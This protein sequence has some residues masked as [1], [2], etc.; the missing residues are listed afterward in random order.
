MCEKAVY[1][2]RHGDKQ[3]LLDTHNSENWG[4][5]IGFEPKFSR[6][7]FYFK[8]AEQG[9]TN[10]ETSESVPMYAFY[11]SFLGKFQKLSI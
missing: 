8:S 5:T 1:I 4:L 11:K 10:T 9:F 3:M 2:H 7:Y 6:F